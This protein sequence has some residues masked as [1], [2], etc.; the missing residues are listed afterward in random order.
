[1]RSR[2]R[3]RIHKVGAAVVGAAMLAV[4]VGGA[5]RALAAAP[6]K[7][8]CTKQAMEAFAPGASGGLLVRISRQGRDTSVRSAIGVC[9]GW[10]Q[11]ALLV[12]SPNT[13]SPHYLAEVLASA[14]RVRHPVRRLLLVAASWPK[15]FS[16]ENVASQLGGLY[17]AAGLRGSVTFVAIPTFTV[18][19][20]VTE[21]NP[22]RDLLWGIVGVLH[23]K[24]PGPLFM[25]GGLPY[26][27]GTLAPILK[28]QDPYGFP[29]WPAPK[30]LGV[31]VGALEGAAMPPLVAYNLHGK[32]VTVRRAGRVVVFLDDFLPADGALAQE[33][34]AVAQAA[35]PAWK[36]RLVVVL[37][38]QAESL[39]KDLKAARAFQGDY[40]LK[41]PVFVGRGAYAGLADGVPSYLSRNAIPHRGLPA[42]TAFR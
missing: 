12:F 1:M 21:S 13:I 27:P 9:Y 39:G 32:A 2:V 36:S 16:R 5:A 29:R 33:V 11:Y 38:G 20:A 24:K 42:A 22:P 37:V 3:K 26:T 18:Q 31:P 40:S 35:S 6:P 28:D 30:A 19:G 14:V 4:L 25:Q 23:G 34:Q 41:V 8:T 15:G 7:D 10:S 17:R